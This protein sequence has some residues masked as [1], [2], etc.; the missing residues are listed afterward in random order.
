ME[1]KKWKNPSIIELSPESGLIFMP[2]A[3]EF[4]KSY[5]SAMSKCRV[6]DNMYFPTVT[7]TF[8]TPNAVCS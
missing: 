6:E 2:M 8:T 5:V 7:F 4:Y 1:K 3:V